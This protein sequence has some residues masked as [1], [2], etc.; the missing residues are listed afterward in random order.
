MSRI[1][2][3]KGFRFF[4]YCFKRKVW[5][6]GEKKKKTNKQ[7]NKNH[8][9]MFCDIHF[10]FFLIEKLSSNVIIIVALERQ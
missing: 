3:L 1:E 9:V 7:K 10:F 6:A 5:R 4:K 2:G 8:K